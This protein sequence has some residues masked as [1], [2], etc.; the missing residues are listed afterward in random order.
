ME[1][2]FLGE[3]ETG[4]EPL[5]PAEVLNSLVAKRRRGGMTALERF[6]VEGMGEEGGGY[7]YG[8]AVREL[9][10]MGVELKWGGGAAASEAG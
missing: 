8:G 7:E 3:R 9:G 10:R 5:W 4:R 6:G 2:T 1:Y